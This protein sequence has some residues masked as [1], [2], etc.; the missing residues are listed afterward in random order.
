MASRTRAFD[1]LL[2]EGVIQSR[3][4]RDGDWIRVKEHFAP[5]NGSSRRRLA[6]MAGQVQ[7]RIVDVENIRV[8]RRA[9]WIAAQRIID[10]QEKRFSQQRRRATTCSRIVQ[11]PRSFV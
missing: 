8:E 11:R 3:D 10:S 6:I 2:S 7:P 5:G 1:G 9:R 4:I